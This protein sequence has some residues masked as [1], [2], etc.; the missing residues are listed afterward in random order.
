MKKK[1]IIFDMD[2]TLTDTAKATT[3]AIRGLSNK[4]ALP[5]V[6]D[7]QV[8]RAMGLPGLDFYKH[9]FPGKPEEELQVIER[10]ADAAEE[11]II[12]AMKKDILFP[13][14]G[15][16]LSILSSEGYCLYVASTGSTRH[17]RSTL[18]T[19]EIRNHFKSVSCNE[20][21]KIMMVKELISHGDVSEWVMVGDM[22]KD[23][24]AARANNI[25]ALG[26]GYGYLAEN[27][28]PLFDSVLQK[29]E[30]IYNYI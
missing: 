22:Y 16:L 23:S 20:P 1:H 18:K 12:S 11:A 26:A 2:G 27:D 17:V 14:I 3:A 9:L 15:D 8:R 6:T 7:K 28:Y 24:E 4:L 13:G 30:E 21:D 10:E 25:L 19:G 29:P 5:A